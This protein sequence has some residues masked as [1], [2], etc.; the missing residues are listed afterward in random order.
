MLM[1]KILEMTAGD[2]AAV[3]TDISD[4]E[5]FAAGY[6]LG[7]DKDN[8]LIA[9]ITPYGKYD[10][11]ITKR[12]DDI[13]QIE[14]DGRYLRKLQDLYVLQ[15]QKYEPICIEEDIICEVLKWAFENE[16]IVSIEMGSSGFSDLQGY[17][18]YVDEETVGILKIDDFGN[19]DGKATA[20]LCN[21]SNVICDSEKEQSLA[22]L[23]A[24]NS[25]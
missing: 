15:N 12:V 19:L 22:I 5:K 25:K 18:D 1:N 17:V 16:K 23:S 6:Y 9:H 4:T 20:E 13:Y 3:Y 8:V 11:Y 10:G 7:A 2:L 24:K 14:K 21:I